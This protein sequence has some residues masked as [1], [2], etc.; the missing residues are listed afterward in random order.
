M[1]ITPIYVNPVSRNQHFVTHGHSVGRKVPPEYHSWKGMRHRCTIPTNDKYPLYGGRGI[2]V[3]DRWMTSFQTFLEDVGPKPGPG[4]SLD[5][6]DVNG[7]YEPGNV[8]WADQ[9]QQCRNKRCNRIV[10]YAGSDMTVAEVTDL[11]GV[12]GSHLRYHLKQGRT[13]DEAVAI[14]LKGRAKPAGQCINGHDLKGDNL[15][16]SPKGNPQC[17]TCRSA[18]RARS[19]RKPA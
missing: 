16:I 18:A 7:N 3:C 1:A 10:Q 8:R 19:R 4:Y 2:K 5:R 17:R 11:T 14:V 9:K 13:A 6:I 15:Y 12:D